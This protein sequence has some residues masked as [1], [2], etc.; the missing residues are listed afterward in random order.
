MVGLNHLEKLRLPGKG[1]IDALRDIESPIVPFEGID[2]SWPP[3]KWKGFIPVCRMERVPSFSRE[4][5]FSRPV[6]LD[7]NALQNGR[8]ATPNE[9]RKVTFT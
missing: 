4:L 2:L 1:G 9:N 5:R 3:Q 8:R 6:S 7:S